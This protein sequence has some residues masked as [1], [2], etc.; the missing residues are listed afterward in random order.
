[1]R[2]LVIVPAFVLSCAGLFAQ[3]SVDSWKTVPMDASRTGV[4]ASTASNVAES[5]GEV[6]G[7]VYYAPNGKR[8]RGSA[9]KA[10]KVMLAAQPAMAEVKG[11]IAYST[12]RMERTAPDCE[13]FNWFVDEMMAAVADSVGRKVDIG[14]AN[15]GGVRVDMP[16]G[17][18]LMDDIMSMFPFRNNLCYLSMKGREVR[19]LLKRMV[20]T[21]YQIVGGCEVVAKG[22]ELVSVKVGGEP[23]DDDKLYGVA[24]ISFLLD[25][26]DGY[27]L[28]DQ[29]E[30]V[31]VCNGYIMD[32]MLAYVRGLTAKGQPVEYGKDNRLVL[33]GEGEGNE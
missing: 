33:L 26:G 31:I 27:K 23:L 10:A 5:M 18:V 20:S 14:I 9:R 11:V 1:M 8:L 25:G 30:E 22:K 24:S 4:V 2:R 29:A 6:R 15:T 21:R 7:R 17:E 13:L 32:T 16:E 12:R 28:R 19:E 3:V